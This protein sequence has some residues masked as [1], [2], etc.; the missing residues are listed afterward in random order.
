MLT[1]TRD[2]LPKRG[3]MWGEEMTA[4]A[5]TAVLS[6]VNTGARYNI[7]S[8]QSGYPNA[9]SAGW[10]FVCEAGNYTF[11]V[12]YM[13]ATQT[14]I[15]DFYIDGASIATGLDTYAAGT[16]WNQ[17][18]TITVNG[19]AAGLH[20]FKYIVNGKNAA[21]TAYAFFVTKVSFKQA[22]D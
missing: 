22:T 2:I 14:G 5:G 15:I 10:N 13:K 7:Y 21:S 16:T 4:L 19:L 1:R 20:T 11:D 6:A 17:V 12:L 9:A 8:Y 3:Q 18:Y